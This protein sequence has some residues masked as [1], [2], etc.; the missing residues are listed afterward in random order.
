MQRT[1]PSSSPR[2]QDDIV[3]VATGSLS[4]TGKNPE[5]AHRAA[6]DFRT[7]IRELTPKDIAHF[8]LLCEVKGLTTDAQK[9][10]LFRCLWGDKCGV[11]CTIPAE[12][13]PSIGSGF[14][15]RSFHKKG[16]SIVGIPVT[17]AYIAF[18]QVREKLPQLFSDGGRV[19]SDLAPETMID[20]AN[21]AGSSVEMVEQALMDLFRAK[22]DEK[23]GISYGRGKWLLGMLGSMIAG[24]IA[25]QAGVE[26]AQSS[27]N[28]ACASSGVSMF[29]AWNAIRAGSAEVGIVGGSECAT[30]AITTYVAFDHMMLRRGALTR[31]WRGNRPPEEALLAFDKLRD[32]F[33]PGDA[34]ALI[35]MMRRR[36][37]DLLKV[38]PLARVLGVA[39]N[40]CQSEKYG[41]SLA[42]GTITGQAAL[43]ERLFAK[44]GIDLKSLPGKLV[45]FLHGTGTQAGGI[46]EIYAAAKVLGDIARDG[47]YIATGTKERDGH[48]LGAA[49]AAN[50]TAAIEAMRHGIAPGFPSTRHV[51]PKL[52]VVDPEVVDKEG[53]VIDPAALNA[54]ADS[55]PCRRHEPLDPDHDLVIAD[56]KGFGG[57]NAAALLEPER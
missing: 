22:V 54:V 19:R 9:Q 39:A 12:Y 35:V 49:F 50:V 26:G 55:V 45:H 42:D 40:T 34:A 36:I 51:D 18:A 15:P 23:I 3:I 38:E 13:F 8:D 43:L 21:G 28:S 2:S 25:S 24:H 46:N 30:G 53:I 20:I 41:K 14:Y 27:S 48:T 6:I 37:A 1:T 5:E 44:S 7:G 47:R 29:N 17:Q 16:E 52:R 33:V 11:G 4:A 56:A 32:G 31:E 10:E 57:T